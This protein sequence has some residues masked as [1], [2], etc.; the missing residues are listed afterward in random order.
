M[1]YAKHNVIRKYKW[2]KSLPAVLNNL[3]RL[4][5]AFARNCVI[6]VGIYH[7][8]T[9]PRNTPNQSN[10]TT[11]LH[12]IIKWEWY[13]IFKKTRYWGGWY[14]LI[15]VHYF[16]FPVLVTKVKLANIYKLPNINFRNTVTQWIYNPQLL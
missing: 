15:Q 16:D 5:F 4:F 14:I 11:G 10:I 12:A 13:F 3:L 6:E 8:S 7:F 2:N 1:I 9:N